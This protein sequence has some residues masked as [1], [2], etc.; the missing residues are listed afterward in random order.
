MIEFLHVKYHAVGIKADFSSTF[1]CLGFFSVEFAITVYVVATKDVF[2]DILEYCSDLDL[3]EKTNHDD[4]L[5]EDIDSEILPRDFDNES[6]NRQDNMGEED[7]ND[8]YLEDVEED[9]NEAHFDMSG[10]WMIWDVWC[11]KFTYQML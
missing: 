8:D 2:D 4:D 6:L 3:L 9:A 5:E 7:E 1:Q 10:L 11:I